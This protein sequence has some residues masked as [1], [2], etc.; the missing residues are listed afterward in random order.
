MTLFSEFH[1]N[2]PGKMENNVVLHAH[3]IKLA[4]QRFAKSSIPN[5]LENQTD[6]LVDDVSSRVEDGRKLSPH[7]FVYYL[8][9][10]ERLNLFK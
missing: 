10:K 6:C 1:P 8:V 9:R 4:G 5:F 3:E 2:R 7:K